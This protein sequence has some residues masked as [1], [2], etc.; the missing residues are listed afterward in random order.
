MTLNE[1][2]MGLMRVAQNSFD[3]EKYLFREGQEIKEENS[4]TMVKP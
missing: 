3:P 1:F 4:Q 2:E